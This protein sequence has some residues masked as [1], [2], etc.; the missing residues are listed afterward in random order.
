MGWRQHLYDP[1]TIFLLSAMSGWCVLFGPLRF[2]VLS[3]LVFRG[4]FVYLRWCCHLSSRD[5]TSHDS[6]ERDDGLKARYYRV[7]TKSC[8]CP[9]QIQGREKKSLEFEQIELFGKKKSALVRICYLF[10]LFWLVFPTSWVTTAREILSQSWR[11][12]RTK[13]NRDH[14]KEK[15]IEWNISPFSL[16]L[17]LIRLVYL[18]ENAVGVVLLKNLPEPNTIKHGAGQ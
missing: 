6:N 13:W 16:S 9:A 12:K 4:D 7:S 8:I 2:P 5:F 14:H 10:V 15:Y 17:S 18:M 1:P 3:T 11:A